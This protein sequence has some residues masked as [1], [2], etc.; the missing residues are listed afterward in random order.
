MT[1]GL[2]NPFNTEWTLPSILLDQLKSSVELKGFTLKM[3]IEAMLKELVFLFSC[4]N[5]SILYTCI[6]WNKL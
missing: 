4:I 5:Q 2:N 6:G 1:I 3:K